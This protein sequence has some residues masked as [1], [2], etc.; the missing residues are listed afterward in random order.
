MRGR[1]SNKTVTIV[2]LLLHGEYT[3]D[4]LENY[5][6]LQRDYIQY[7]ILPRIKKFYGTE[8]I[9]TKEQGDRAKYSICS[10]RKYPTKP[11]Y[12]KEGCEEYEHE[13][14]KVIP[15]FPKQVM[16]KQE[17]KDWANK[18]IRI[19]NRYSCNTLFR[20]AKEQG[21]RV[22]DYTKGEVAALQFSSDFLHMKEPALNWGTSYRPVGIGGML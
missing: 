12:T 2:N 1:Q 6:G 17:I 4:E 21:I 20:M 16:S 19:A 15:H 22:I 7:S 11:C 18:D 14:V 5:T 9:R 10:T 8:F 13:E 3:A